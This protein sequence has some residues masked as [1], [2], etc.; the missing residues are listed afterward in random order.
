VAVKA[1][2]YR[3]EALCRAGRHDEAA[4][5][6]SQALAGL[7]AV[8]P[9]DMYLPEAWSIAQRAFTGAGHA[10]AAGDVVRTAQAWIAAAANDLPPEFRDSFMRRNA[11]NR[12]MLA[13]PV[14]A[15]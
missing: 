8:K 15:G 1:R 2:W 12:A 13:M 3:I 5:L 6:A 4:A 11:V 9:W 7:E 10:R 14:T